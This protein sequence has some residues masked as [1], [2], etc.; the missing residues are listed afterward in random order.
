MK[1][2]VTVTVAALAALV[3]S[4]PAFAKHNGH[5]HADSHGH[6]AKHYQGHEHHFTRKGHHDNYNPHHRNSGSM[7]GGS[8]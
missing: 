7:P 5:K 2:I 8:H 6:A 4:A 1:K 3:V